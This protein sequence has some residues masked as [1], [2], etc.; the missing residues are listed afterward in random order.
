MRSNGQVRT[1]ALVVA[2][3]FSV[4][5]AWTV[6]LLAYAMLGYGKY[7]YAFYLRMW[8]LAVGFVFFNYAFRLYH[9][10]LLHPAAPVSP[11]EELRRLV[12]SSFFVHTMAIAVIAVARQTVVD[13]S[14]VVTI[15]ACVVTAILA[16]PIRDLVRAVLFRLGWGQIPVILAGSGKVAGQVASALKRNAYV[17]FRI[18]GYCDRERRTDWGLVRLG[19]LGRV[20]A[21]ARKRGVRILLACQDEKHFRA[22]MQEFTKW[23]WHVEY[24]PSADVFPVYGSRTISFDGLGGVELVNQ[25]LMRNLKNEKW[26]LDKALTLLALIALL[27]LFV[28]I[29]VLIKLTSRGPVFYRQERL[30]RYGE[31]FGI[32][33]FRSMYADADARMARLRAED[34]SVNA[35]WTSNFK[36]RR[37]PRITPLGRFLRKTSL[38]EIPQLFNVISGSMALVGPRPIVRDEVRYYGATAYRIFSSVKPG[39]TGLWQ[40]SGRSETGYARRVLLDCQYVLNWSP[41]LDI[42]I[43]MRTISAVFLMR[44]AC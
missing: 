31:R 38:D 41:W 37:D 21:E 2:D 22:K 44:G 12:S 19:G 32:W 33:K 7:H 6:S 30:G 8:P 23:F 39:I 4:T 5:V 11:V 43:L 20:T 14:R 1:L 42:W 17:G 26:L 15:M 35:E 27:P 28:I 40:C 16:Q 25:G 13:Y 10:S 18:V 36:L 9:G 24:L 3:I 34:A 29:P